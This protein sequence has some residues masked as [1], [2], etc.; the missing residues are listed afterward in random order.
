MTTAG[1]VVAVTMWAT[2]ASAAG[3]PKLAA[4]M[5][6]QAITAYEHGDYARASQLYL[7][8][9]RAEVGRPD[10]VY[11]AAR[12]EQL[13]A[14]LDRADDLYTQALADPRLPDTL[15]DKAE[16]YRREVRILR[17]EAKIVE[18]DKAFK[19]GESQLAAQ[20]YH[21]AY[22]AAPDRHAWLFKAALAEQAAGNV[23]AARED[24]ATYLERAPSEAEDRK[25]AQIRL[26]AL[27]KPAPP[28]AH[29]AV[30][31]GADAQEQPS[32]WPG[33]VAVAAGAG[34]AGAGVWLYLAQ[35]DERESLDAQLA[36][37]QG[38]KVSGV[39]YQT[40]DQQR[41]SLNASYR[42]AAILGGVG[43]ASVGVGIWWLARA[44]A[45]VS[46]GPGS[47]SVAWGF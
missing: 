26:E 20:L 32:R 8:A 39:D 41:T 16:T 18:A 17:A 29:L 42:N 28:G 22:V 9:A 46:V 7:E 6:Q 12:A 43:L 36:Q 1:I 15:R 10:Y 30:Q 13:A 44:P 23:T 47:V 24:Y 33:W 25:Q 34:L 45:R 35:G 40:Y 37:R 38:G 19:G 31:A 3:K 4:T 11:A 5:A 21:D 14:Q 27:R 2:A